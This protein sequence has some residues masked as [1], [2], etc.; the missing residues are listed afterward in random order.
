M[1]VPPVS[2]FVQA[3][4]LI[5]FVLFWKSGICAG[6][7]ISNPP[8]RTAGL[9]NKAQRDYQEAWHSL[10]TWFARYLP[11]LPVLSVLLQRTP[12]SR[13]QKGR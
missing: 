9:G 11:L 10:P 1:H 13:S 4:P 3:R 2:K 8:T 5:R 12:D 7:G 6:E